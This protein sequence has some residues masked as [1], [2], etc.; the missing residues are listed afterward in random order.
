MPEG[1]DPHVELDRIYT[2]A[3]SMRACKQRIPLIL[4]QID[5]AL[6]NPQTPLEQRI[7]IWDMVWNR[8]HG[9]PRQQVFI[10]DQT[11]APEKRV[12]VYIPDNNRPNTQPRIIEAENA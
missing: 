11:N 4:S 5:E 6:C 1:F 2:L 10:N 9:K 3:E 8:A 7:K 12:Q